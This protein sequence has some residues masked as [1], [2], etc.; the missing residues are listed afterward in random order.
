MIRSLMYSE[1]PLSMFRSTPASITTPF[2][3]NLAVDIHLKPT[4]EITWTASEK[5]VRIWSAK[6]EMQLVCV[7]KLGCY[8]TTHR[9]S[10]T[11]VR[12]LALCNKLLP[13]VSV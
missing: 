4:K 2:S 13:A 11:T 5:K 9:V 3:L 1:K 12:R 10:R 6:S 8:V 7:A